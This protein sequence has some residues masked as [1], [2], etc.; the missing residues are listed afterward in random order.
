MDNI[1]RN[2]IDLLKALAIMIMVAGHL[3]FSL[4]PMF[5][6]YSF[7]VMLFFFIAG[8]LFNNKYSFCEY[9][10]RRSVSL[11]FPYFLYAV[12]YLLLTLLIT[13]V[14]GKFWGMPVTL[15]NE[16]IMPFL[17]GHQIDL[18]SPM[19]FVPCLFITLIIY[20]LLSSVKC[21]EISKLIFYFVLALLAIYFQG[22]AQDINFLWI[23][24]TMFALLFVHL[25]YLYKQN[26]YNKINIF[27]NRILC[28][29]LILQSVLWFT[30]KDFTPYDGVGLHFL[31]VWGQYNNWIVPILTS[32]TGIWISL[33]IIEIL[34]EKI[35]NMPFL[36]KIGK[37]TYHIMA[38]HLL[39]FNILTYSFLA[40]KGIPFDIK[41]NADIYW[42][43]FPLKTTYF[44][45]IFGIL[46]T[47]YIG[48]C[49][50]RIKNKLNKITTK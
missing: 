1:F 11:I 9:L 37:N 43:Y 41:N 16:L 48:E 2:K 5:P 39:I 47:T 49:L 29:V 6:P 32:L 30:N 15:K 17:T 18:I 33:Y 36:Q 14:I 20:K 34:Y 38:N 23:F 3:E 27:S 31:L 50:N 26:I 25:G 46:I 13:P 40:I 24:R 8:I 19:W 44:Y 12:F 35:K 21:N 45:F 4:I 42:F 28:F 10:K 7:Q 22:F